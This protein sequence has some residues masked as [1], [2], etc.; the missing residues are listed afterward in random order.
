MGEALVDVLPDGSAVPGGGPMNAAVTVARLGRQCA[1]VGRVSTDLEGVAIWQH[2]M[3]SGVNL[4]AAERGSEP[5]A[6]A[7]VDLDGPQLYR[8]EGDSTADTALSQINLEPLG[9]GPHIVHGGTLGIFRG[10]TAQVLADFIE[11]FDGLVSF[12]PNI[13]SEIIDQVGEQTWWSFA[14]RWLDRADLIRGSDEDLQWMQ[15]TPA[16]LCERGAKAVI[17]TKGPNG[18]ELTLASGETLAVPARQVA[19]VDAVGAGDAFCGAVLTKLDELGWPTDASDWENLLDFA[20]RVAG[21]TCS[22]PGADPPWAWEL[23]V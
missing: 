21:V 1:Y 5:T 16:E 2:M 19:F 23:S 4:E 13:R 22:R 8:F 3:S 14:N 12:D 9:A 17:M 6:K 18:A 10:Q 20:V 7:I 11:G 15:T